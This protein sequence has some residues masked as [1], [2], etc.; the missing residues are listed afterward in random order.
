[1]SDMLMDT[2]ENV[3]LYPVFYEQFLKEFEDLSEGDLEKK[4]AE[5]KPSGFWGTISFWT[6]S[7]SVQARYYAAVEMLRKKRYDPDPLGLF[8]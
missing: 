7:P 8:K 6:S 4:V 2:Q 1:M 5:L 3:D